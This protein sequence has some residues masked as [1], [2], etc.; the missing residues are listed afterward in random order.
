MERSLAAGLSASM[1]YGNLLNASDGDPVRTNSVPVTESPFLLVGDH[2]GSAIPAR[3]NRLGLSSKDRSRHIALDL[4]VRELGLALG[5]RLN[6]PFLWQHF[7]RLICDCNRNPED[8]EWAA[9]IS[10]GTTVPGNFRLDE[11]DKRA[12][13]QS[14]FDPYHAAI[15]SAISRRK[16]AGQPTI[17]VSLHSFTFSM[18]GQQRPWDIGILHDSHEDGFALSVLSLLRAKESYCIGDNEPYDM[19]ETDYTAPRHAFPLKLSYIEIEVRQDI[20]SNSAGIEKMA[21]LLGDTLQAALSADSLHI[22]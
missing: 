3:L 15:A 19:D 2:A 13:R 9:Q 17:F 6:A 12:R 1:S 21:Y 5:K 11:Q 10:D 4:G 16:A 8:P 18:A 22:E 14:I 7:S 20:L